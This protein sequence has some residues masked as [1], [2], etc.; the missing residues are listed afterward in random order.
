M[1]SQSKLSSW[2]IPEPA[3]D[4]ISSINNFIS[5]TRASGNKLLKSDIIIFAKAQE[6]ADLQTAPIDFTN[7]AILFFIPKGFMQK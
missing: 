4:V 2:A 5:Q 7:S 1:I 3:I 6:G